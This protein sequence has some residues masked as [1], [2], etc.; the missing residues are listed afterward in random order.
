MDITGNFTLLLIAKYNIHVWKILYILSIHACVMN[1]A[2]ST[3][4]FNATNLNLRFRI[5]F[6]LFT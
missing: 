2:S 3:Y 6:M 4:A 1:L 5:F